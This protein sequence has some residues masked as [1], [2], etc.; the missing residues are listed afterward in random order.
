MAAFL[1]WLHADS[2]A[3]LMEFAGIRGAGPFRHLLTD[4]LNE[5]VEESWSLF[6]H[7]RGLYTR[8]AVSEAYLSTVL[9]GR[10]RRRLKNQERRLGEHGN[11]QY[12]AL[13]PGG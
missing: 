2:G 7:T 3:I 6:R 8:R 4:S 12:E 11:L 1:D 9:D 10:T 13:E 5:R